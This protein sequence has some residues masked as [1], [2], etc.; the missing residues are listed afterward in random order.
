[1]Q[2]R[3][4]R[5]GRGALQ[6]V[7][8]AMSVVVAATTALA[9]VSGCRGEMSELDRA[10][11]QAAKQSRSAEAHLALGRALLDAGLPN[12]AYVAFSRARELDPQGVEP[13]FELARTNLELRAAD[14]GIAMA[15]EAL[16]RDPKHVRAREVLGRLLLAKGDV[17]DAI[18][19]LERATREA[20]DFAEAHVS[21]ASAHARAGDVQSA[22]RVA[23]RAAAAHPRSAEAHVVY[24][25]LLNRTDDKELAEKHYRAAIA[26]DA[27]QSGAMVRLAALLVG[28]G[29]D[30]QEARELAQ[31]AEGLDPADGAAA[32]TAAWALYKMGNTRDALQELYLCA[33]AFPYNHRVWMLFHQALREQGMEEQAEAALRMAMQVAP[34]VP[35]TPEQRR[36]LRSELAEQSAEGGPVAVDIDALLGRGE[37]RDDEPAPATDTEGGPGPQ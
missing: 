16:A 37:P 24:A 27:T 17:E 15:R 36:R 1:M 31:K 13:A 30:L 14:Q 35:L 28:Q 3:A 6:V 4:R 9:V 25:D 2:T 8:R 5:E 11:R 21:L 26:L 23:R 34:R 29:R 10:R 32:A 20:P 19:E 7:V 12:D 22:L 33:R 18:R